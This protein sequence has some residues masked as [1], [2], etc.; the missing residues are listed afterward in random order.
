MLPSSQGASGP[1]A[2]IGLHSGPLQ[3][4]SGNH[5]APKSVLT[6]LEQR[7]TRSESINDQ[8]RNLTV[9]LVIDPF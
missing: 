1:G 8:I 2:R 9:R 7:S 4:V 6:R 3:Q 5:A